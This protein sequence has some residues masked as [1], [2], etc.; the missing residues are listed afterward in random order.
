MFAMPPPKSAA[1]PPVIVTSFSDR[2]PPGPSTSNTR[3]EFVPSIVAPFPFTLIRDVT[4]GS[5]FS[6]L[7]GVVRA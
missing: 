5:P 4:T 7:S 6:P 3:T 1:D 2:F